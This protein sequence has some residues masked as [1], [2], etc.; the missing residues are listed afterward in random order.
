M[1]KANWIP[2]VLGICEEFH[3]SYGK[4]NQDRRKHLEA[5]SA[6]IRECENLEKEVQLV[7]IC[8][9]N[10][11]RSH[12]G[13][14]WLQV[15]S[16]YYG[17]NMRVYSGGTE[18]TAFHPNAV[19]AMRRFGFE[20]SS[21]EGQN[22]TYKLRHSNDSMP[23]PCFSK[24]FDHSENPHD[25][26]AAILVCNDA[27]EACPFVPGAN[28]RFVLPYNDPKEYDGTDLEEQK[29]DER[30]SEIGREM[31]YVISRI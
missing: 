2:K 13:Q 31:F 9:H 14:V 29:Y 26:F 3:Q 7:V 11:R 20:V 30:C 5:I 28:E 15:A 4:I 19:K 24:K 18:A 27:A 6:Y 12:F 22:P 1:N 8:T 10:S 17:H 21:S 16:E 23:I 25:Q